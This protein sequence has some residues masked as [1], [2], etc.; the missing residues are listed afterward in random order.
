MAGDDMGER[1]EAATPRKISKSRQRGQVAKSQD[2]SAAVGL[3]AA[4]VL[5]A[6]FGASL[7]RHFAMVLTRVWQGQTPGDVL[8][9]DGIIGASRWVGGTTVLA[10]LPIFGLVFLIAYLTNVLQVGWLLTLEPVKPKLNKVSPV[11]G[12]KRLLSLRS[13]MKGLVNGLKL[14]VVGG[15]ATLVLW[16]SIPKLTA[17]PRL[18]AELALL[19]IGKL[20]VELAL[21]LLL[22]LLVLA[23]VDFLYQ[24][25]QHKKDLKMTKHEVK[26]ERRSMEGD[27]QVKKQRMKMAMEVA[28]QRIQSAVP[29]A[30]VVVANPTHFSV[31]LKYDSDSMGAPRLVAKGADLLAYRIRQVAIANAVPIVERP[32]LARAIYWGVEVGHEIPPHLYEAV[33]ELLAYV[34]QTE[35]SAA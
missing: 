25:W 16:R 13:L 35:K 34:Y 26:D 18:N 2:L 31:A 6:I 9:M 17:L 11:A 14:L 24:R 1:S 22:V 3:A 27:P 28:T 4:V 5:L 8:S 32:P 15:I 19:A 12:L 30:D 33:A 7:L 21:W 20:A 29:D 23:V 10:V